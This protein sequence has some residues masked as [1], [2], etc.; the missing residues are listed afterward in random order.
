MEGDG[1]PITE[2]ALWYTWFMLHCD[3]CSIDTE[4][5]ILEVDMGRMEVQRKYTGVT[6]A[7]IIRMAKASV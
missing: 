5:R 6:V 7:C 4:V 1:E 2:I 3:I